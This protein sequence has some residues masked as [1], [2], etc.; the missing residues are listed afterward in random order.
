MTDQDD[1][2]TSGI[3][4]FS[5]GLGDGSQRPGART[6]PPAFRVLIFGDFAAKQGTS[7]EITGKDMAELLEQFSPTLT[8]EA[9]NLLGSLPAVLSEELSFTRPRDFKPANLVK[10]FQFTSDIKTA[11]AAGGAQGLR[12][13]GQRFD[14]IAGLISR[15]GAAASTSQAQSSSGDH[16][17]NTA[18]PQ[19][20]MA[21]PADGGTGE[22]DG[23]DALFSMVDAPKKSPDSP[24]TQDLAK[25]AVE[26]FLSQ[27]TSGTPSQK[28]QDDGV[29]AASGTPEAEAALTAQSLLFLKDKRLSLVL[30]NW[31]SLK[32]LLNELPR[33]TSIRLFLVQ[34]DTDMPA[35]E[36]AS[37]LEGNGSLLA[38][39]AFDILLCANRQALQKAGAQDLKRYAALAAEHASCVFAGLFPDFAGLPAT[40]LGLLD[41]PHTLLEGTGFE[42]FSSLRQSEPAGSLGLFWNDGVTTAAAEDQ[43][44]AY[45]PSAWIALL[46]LLRGQAA[47]G[48]PSLPQGERLEIDDLETTER[49][50]KGRVFAD[51]VLAHVTPD[52]AESLASAGINALQGQANR[53]SVYFG[54][55]RVARS[56]SDDAQDG[57]ANLTHALSLGRLNTLLQVAFSEAPPDAADMSGTVARLQDQLNLLSDGLMDRVRF[58]VTADTDEDGDNVL[59]IDATVAGVPGITKPFG[60]RIGR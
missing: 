10:Q 21:S 14:K 24:Q 18:S 48:W 55:A 57:R 6:P 37:L 32:T 54:S 2:K 1:D 29:S 40:D 11:L 36:A 45:M 3:K 35:E 7:A 42:H 47:D 30:E 12:D 9:E 27:T 26:A 52:A 50:A 44:A 8:V 16:A 39:A 5:V 20:P 17:P 22:D 41:T 34:V 59:D 53:T 31:L 43:P 46:A 19:T 13:A 4:S 25:Q 33:E 23:L 60:F 51:S 38:T 15:T 49:N 28:A 56:V 58:Q